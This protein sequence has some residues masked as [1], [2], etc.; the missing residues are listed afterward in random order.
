MP[1]RDLSSSFDAP[2]GAHGVG[3]TLLKR[4]KILPHPREERFPDFYPS[5]PVT[6]PR[7]LVIDTGTSSMPGS[8]SSSPRTLK[9]ASKRISGLP[10]TPPTHSRQSSGGHPAI[11]PAPKFDIASI[12]TD[13]SSVPSTPVN[14]RSPPTPDV[15]P[16]RAS[17]MPLAFR[18]HPLTT[19][20]YP[21]SR[22]D[23]FKTARETLSDD[24]DEASTVRPGLPSAR[25]SAI[26]IPQMPLPKPQKRKEIGLGLGLETDEGA[27]TPKARVDS[28]QEEFV[29]FDGE[30]GD[31][32][33][34]EKEW[35]EN[36]MRNVTVRKRP[37]R[38][39]HIFTD[40]AGDEVLE[41]DIIVPTNATKVVRSLPLEERIARHRLARDTSNRGPTENFAER[42]AWPQSNTEPES[43]L[44]PDVRRF[45][46]MSGPSVTST[47]IEA[48]V[49]DA[50][51][52]RRKTLRHT[53]KH[54]GLRDLSSDVSTKSSAPT[55]VSS[56]EPPHRLHH[57]TAKLPGRRHQS[58]TSSGTNGTISTTSS[59][60]K[61]RRQVLKSGAIPVVVIPER[62][63]S[64][65]SRAPSLRSTSSRKS[66]RSNSLN[67][68]P[69]SQSSKY[70]DPG[71]FDTLPPRK[72]TMSESAGSGHSVRTIDYPPNIPA[73][74]S[75]LS[76]PT[77]R[78]TSRA[79]SLTAESLTAHNMIQA[80]KE[81]PI[82]KPLD[83]SQ[84]PEHELEK[85]SG[86]HSHRLHV[87]HNGD[88][89]FGNRL[90]TQVTPFSAASYE[91]A[92]MAEL[93][94]AMAVTIFPHQNKSVLVVQHP[95][96][97]ESS[98][99]QLQVFPTAPAPTMAVNGEATTGPTTPPQ[100]SHPMDTV[101]SPLRNPRNP[102]EPPAIKFIPPTPASLTPSQEEDR[103]LGYGLDGL[104]SPN[105]PPKRTMSLMR[106]FSNRSRS[107]G[108]E[109][110]GFLTRTFS[111]SG[112]RKDNATQTSK[113]EAN[114]STAYP[115][116][117]DQP[118]DGTKLHPFW[119]PAHFWD[120]LE[121]QDDEFDEYGDRYPPI[122]DRPVPHRTFSQKLKRTFAILPIQDDFESLPYATDRRTVRRTPSEKLRVVKKRSGSSLKRG[123]D[124]RSW[125]D[126]APA[127]IIGPG[128]FG[129]GFR[130]GNGGRSHIIPGIGFRVEYVGWSGMKKML[131]ERR[132]QQRSEKLRA[133]ISAPRG[134]QNGI[135]DVLRRRNHA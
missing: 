16:P 4:H 134:V 56:N 23:S 120:D 48:M 129:Y 133:S 19:D 126:A 119:R 116:V 52:L 90:S 99:S 132:R 42:V 121:D 84:H 1:S 5:T 94:E 135:D 9:H 18:P 34:V 59:D 105:E 31:V 82:P 57:A 123:A 80:R 124:R 65:R 43:P 107:E 109:R 61:S 85:D 67:S 62:R 113:P 11:A 111:L 70:N 15:T 87:D 63:S 106:R 27:T 69:L 10:P 100:Q 79:G 74:R 8:D 88:P 2:N 114:L 13:A 21:S 128:E 127:P 78:N 40:G 91:T 36:L 33:E 60:G 131:S 64:S 66:K 81:E 83:E 46:T 49:V 110:P 68:A 130:D 72:R 103:Q 96:S 58:V 20:R 28:S 86:S 112:R 125:S 71:Y 92:T 53:K 47:V 41:D 98:G 30:W 29:V 51:V 55:S 77:S 45:S 50:P 89:F 38:S 101:D 26:E 7:D 3:A 6:K 17:R 44:L 95:P 102:P 118:A 39:R 117:A 37:N 75:S 22:T 115:S 54:V 104:S 76:A 73:R 32:S 97:S 12:K 24:E 93:S 35:D 25:P 108:V 14:Q 122:N